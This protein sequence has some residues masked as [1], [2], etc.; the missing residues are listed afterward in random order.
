[1]Q[2]KLIMLSVSPTANSWFDVLSFGHMNFGRKSLES[3]L[4]WHKV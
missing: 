3:D 2:C 4:K 1:V